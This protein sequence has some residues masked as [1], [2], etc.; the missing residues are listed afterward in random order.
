[1]PLL[2]VTLVPAPDQVVVRLNGDADLSTVPLLADALSQAARLGT[3]HLVVDL[4]GARFWDSSGLRTLTGL[5]HELE[6]TGRHCRLVGAGPRTRRLIAAAGLTD[7]LE[8]DGPAPGPVP[9]DP[10]AEPRPARRPPR[11][12]T[13]P[14]VPPSRECAP[15]SRSPRAGERVAGPGGQLRWR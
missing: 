8:L 10:V 1:V 13:V 12:R 7:L 4:A 14:P 3:P 15:S 2:N 11:A 9:P 5:T 6:A